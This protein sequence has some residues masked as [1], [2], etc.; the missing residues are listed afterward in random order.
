M[1]T[2]VNAAFLPVAAACAAFAVCGCTEREAVV[3][4]PPADFERGGVTFDFEGI[5]RTKTDYDGHRPD[6]P[7]TPIRLLERPFG[8]LDGRFAVSEGQCGLVSFAWK[9]DSSVKCATDPKD[10]RFEIE[11]PRGYRLL[12]T[13]FGDVAS[14]KAAKRPDGSSLVTCRVRDGFRPSPWMNNQ[15]T[16]NVLV[17]AEDG[18]SDGVLSMRV[19]APDGTP[20][21]TRERVTLYTVPAVRARAVPKRFHNGFDASYHLNFQEGPAY[22]ELARLFGDIGAG[23]LVQFA[24]NAAFIPYWRKYAHGPVTPSWEKVVEN[25]FRV[26]DPAT[27]PDSERF[28]CDP[29]SPRLTRKPGRAKYLSDSPCPVTVYRESEHFLNDTIARLKEYLKGADGLWGNWE[30]SMFYKNGCWCGRCRDEFARWSKKSAAD[31]AANWPAA[32]QEGGK[33]AKEGTRFRSWQHANVVKTIDRHVRAATGGE[34]S[35]GFIPGIASVEMSSYW[36]KNGYPHEMLQIDYSGDVE[37]MN[38]WGPYVRWQREKPYE[39]EKRAPLVTWVSAVDVRKTVE[40][41]HP[42]GRVPKLLSYPQ[43]AQCGTWVAQPEFIGLALDTYMLNGWGANCVYYFPNGY[44]ARYLAAFAA[45]NE[46]AAVAEDFVLDG[47]RSDASVSAVPVPEFAAPVKMVSAWLP[48]YTNV[49][50][51]Q[52]RSF[53]LK[54]SRLV[55]AINFWDEAP[56]FFDLCCRDLR[57]GRYTVVADGILWAKD[58]KRPFWTAQELS[59]G[60]RLAVGAL[61][62]AFFEVR[63]YAANARIGARSVMTRAMVDSL[64]AEKRPRLK[65]LAE[66]D[67]AEERARPRPKQDWMGLN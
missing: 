42:D 21:S 27:L 53:D 54:G 12:G 11:V 23:W 37:W 33:W 28:V 55:A 9:R 8:F 64:Y 20:L 44:D 4:L 45:A 15:Y 60:I 52:T 1:K 2:K 43:G 19:V 10:Y 5:S 16:C 65:A 30:P 14:R 58:A 41:D 13:T 59:G 38:P 17:A 56:A 62:S 35:V 51:L 29:K 18:A 36:H 25:G 46:R 26:G 7:K 6:A 47:V 34:K 39:R 63:P 57:P 40:L 67:A 31:V 48:A 32:V 61:R 22:E 24:E 3:S 50:M 66:R 49:S